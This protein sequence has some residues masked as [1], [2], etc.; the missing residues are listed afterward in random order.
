MKTLLLATSLFAGAPLF[1]CDTFQTFAA[2]PSKSSGT[3]QPGKESRPKGETKGGDRTTRREL[4]SLP[5]Y[6]FM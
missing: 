5:P 6:L 2:A 1:A 3:A 4:P